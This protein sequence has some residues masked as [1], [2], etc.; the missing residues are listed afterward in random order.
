MPKL[1]GL[2]SGGAGL[3]C[4]LCS[5]L[6]GHT[7]CLSLLFCVGKDQESQQDSELHGTPCLR[8]GSGPPPHQE[9]TPEGGRALCKYHPGLRN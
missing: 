1:T 4:G 5:H 7:H 2:G 9:V 3:R 6:P 8:E